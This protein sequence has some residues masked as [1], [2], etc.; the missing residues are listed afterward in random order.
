MRQTWN[1][2]TLYDE[3]HFDTFL[4]ALRKQIFEFKKLESM[5]EKLL[6]AQELRLSIHQASSFANCLLAVDTNHKRAHGWESCLRSISCDLEKIWMEIDVDLLNM[7]DAKIKSLGEP[8]IQFPLKERRDLAKLRLDVEQEHLISDLAVDGYHS[9]GHFYDS[10]IATLV[11]P[12]EGEDLSVAQIATKI[13][14]S[15]R[16]LREKALT[17]YKEIYN[18]NAPIIARSLNHLAGFK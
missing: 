8:A 16:N 7:S 18:K 1:L 13:T 4:L 2:K 5:K 17:S 11:F 14:S 9:W 10:F 6:L 3:A 15:D 12:L